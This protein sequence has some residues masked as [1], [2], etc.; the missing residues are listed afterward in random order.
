[1]VGVILNLTLFFGYH[2]LWPDGFAGTFDWMSALIV[3]AATIALFRFKRNIIEVIAVCAALG[4]ILK[5]IV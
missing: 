2:V 5:T 3:L 1:M 4:F